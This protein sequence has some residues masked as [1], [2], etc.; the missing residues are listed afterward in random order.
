MIFLTP[1][2]SHSHSDLITQ[3]APPL[4]GP[5]PSRREPSARVQAPPATSRAVAG[6]RRKTAPPAVLTELIGGRC[7][8]TLSVWGDNAAAVRLFERHGFAVV[9]EQFGSLL[10]ATEADG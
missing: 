8:V 3:I 2:I 9:A 1:S 10:M 7:R 6:G 5:E 4:C